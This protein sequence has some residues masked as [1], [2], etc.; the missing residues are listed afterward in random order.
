MIRPHLDAPAGARRAWLIAALL[1]VYVLAAKLG[2]TFAFVH[3][4]AS[5]VWPPTGIALGAFLIFGSRVWPAIF[6]GALLVNVT[7]AGSV[8]SSLGI[9]TGNTLEGLIGAYL[10]NRFAGGAACF[11][12]A[13]TIFPFAA[14]AA[15]LATTVSA[16][17]GVSSLAAAGYAAWSDFGAIWLT[18]WLGDAAGAL[19]V[20]PLIVLWDRRNVSHLPDD[21]RAEAVLMYLVNIGLGIAIF[22]G[23][24][25]G[26]YPL[27]FL[28][29]P[30]LAW[31][32]FRFGP[33][34]VATA[35]VALSVIAAWAT[36]SGLGPLVMRTPNESLLVLQSF[37]ATV[38]LMMLPIAAL[39]GEHRYAIAQADSANRAKDEF[40]AMLSHELRN[41]L[42]AM[43]N[44]VGLLR[45][46]A[47]GQEITRFAVDVIGR[48]SDHLTRL[49]SDL[50]D[51]SR[52]VTG[53]MVLARKVVDLEDVVRQVV[54]TL[55]AAGRVRDHTIEVRVEP[56][57][58]NA[59]P[60]RLQ[61]V[62][63][64]LVGN[65]LKFTPAGGKIQIWVA[66]RAG[67]AVLRV[68]DNGIGITGEMLPKVFDP[69][70]Q[71]ERSLDRAAGGLGI[72]LTL[73][74]R[75][76]E[77]HGGRVEAESDGPDR[78][79]TFEVRLPLAAPPESE[80]NPVAAAP[81]STLPR[82]ILIVE[83]NPD[84]RAT[85]KILLQA[86][87][88]EVHEAAD[89]EVGIAEALRLRADVSLIDIGLP[90]C[91]GYEVA[92]RIRANNIP[93]RLI[94]ITGYGQEH[95][96][97]RSFQAGFDEHL[98]KPVDPEELQRALPSS[99]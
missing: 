50:L 71:G 53:K 14:F 26:S 99:R 3:A 13:R 28:C 87:G 2:L 97:R 12:R 96:R 92:R 95:D 8:A 43:G 59:D 58:V 17:I 1:T 79:S 66:A 4:S 80:T 73:V 54:A 55:T 42:Q 16:T 31:A 51:L 52:A 10:V 19:I 76:V 46:P 86:M 67:E 62:V 78:G 75:L 45:Q 11:E 35:I 23:A 33:R 15:L 70:T 44:A 65:A 61:Q 63:S 18:W 72:G 94:A 93:M 38:M 77:Q 48:Q 5:A 57:W 82:R 90:G 36:V 20:T 85:L 84:A 91:D 60:Q 56:V 69:F 34:E 81:V 74:R 49:V 22:G 98:V 88:H 68:E 32:A 37:M 25:L 83:G 6:I 40:L 29:L 89:G 7:T 9:A 21:R 30:P 47:A 27:A 64:N 24:I 39:V 41:P